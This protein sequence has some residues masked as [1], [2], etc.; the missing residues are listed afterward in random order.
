MTIIFTAV[1]TY[2]AVRPAAQNGA[3]VHAVSTAV[4]NSDS[5][6]KLGPVAGLVG[7]LEQRLAESPEDAKG[8]LLLAKSY[9]HLGDNQKASTAYAR[10]VELGLSDAEFEQKLIQRALTKGERQ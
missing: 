5:N 4:E 7:G 2:I 3:P 10:A 8:W 6:D 9:D 1:V